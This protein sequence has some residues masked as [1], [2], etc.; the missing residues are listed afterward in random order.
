MRSRYRSQ[1][2]SDHRRRI[3]IFAVVF[4][5]ERVVIFAFP[6]LDE[7]FVKVIFKPAS[8]ATLL[9]YQLKLRLMKVL[10]MHD[11]L[12]IRLRSKEDDNYS[13]KNP[14]STTNNHL[15]VKLKSRSPSFSVDES[16]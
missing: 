2:V 4:C 5:S 16:A 6:L 9:Y 12:L 8:G 10:H 7:P 15:R 1:K 11:Y 3:G 14:T 13:Q